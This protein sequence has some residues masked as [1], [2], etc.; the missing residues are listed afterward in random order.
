MILGAAGIGA[1]QQFLEMLDVVVAPDLT[2]RLAAAHAFD[3]RG[4]VELVGE[5]DAAGQDVAQRR[6]RRVV[7]DVARREEERRFLAVQVG[8][9]AFEL[10]VEVR[11]ARDVARAA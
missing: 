11:R 10:D 4:V 5:D 2:L 9:F 1:P 6:E 3:H 7:G 8:E